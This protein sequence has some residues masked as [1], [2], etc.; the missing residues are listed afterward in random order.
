MFSYN[1]SDSDTR[2]SHIKELFP[3]TQ[4][5]FK[6]RTNNL[7]YSIKSIKRQYF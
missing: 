2:I 3:L 7:Y 6:V 1:S 4:A 5:S